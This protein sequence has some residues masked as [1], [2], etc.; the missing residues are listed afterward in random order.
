M[1]Q[2]SQVCAFYSGSLVH[3]GW[4]GLVDHELNHVIGVNL[5]IKGSLY[6]D[7]LC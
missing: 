6:L 1:A 2:A 7:R 4:D 3:L 5:D